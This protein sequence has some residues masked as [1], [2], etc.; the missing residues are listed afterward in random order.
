MISPK[1]SSLTDD[2]IACFVIDPECGFESDMIADSVESVSDLWLLA[3]MK[4][5]YDKENDNQRGGYMPDAVCDVFS[6]D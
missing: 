5:T 2:A 1:F 4:E 3:N 6:P